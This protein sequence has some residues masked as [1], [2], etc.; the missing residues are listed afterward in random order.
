MI[1]CVH[2]EIKRCIYAGIPLP[3]KIYVHIDGASENTA[4]ASMAAMEHL[5]GSGKRP[6]LSIDEGA[7]VTVADEE[8]KV[9][10]EDEDS[11]TSSDEGDD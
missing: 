7:V 10:S 1:H 3:E 5:I 2:A 11:E 9:A 6:C 4:Y 8:T